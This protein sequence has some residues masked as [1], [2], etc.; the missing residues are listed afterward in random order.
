MADGGL[1]VNA[2]DA[3][4]WRDLYCTNSD[5]LLLER[6]WHFSHGPG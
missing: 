6:K 3:H 5:H 1:L 2:D 4:F